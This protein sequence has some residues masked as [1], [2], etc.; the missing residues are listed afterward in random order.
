MAR[1]KKAVAEESVKAVRSRN[2]NFTV[3]GDE[4]VVRRIREA[5]PDLHVFSYDPASG[6]VN[7]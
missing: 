6:E 1:F 5:A 4:E 2:R 3:V 7:R